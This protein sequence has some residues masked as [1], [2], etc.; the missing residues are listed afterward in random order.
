MIYIPEL[1][2]K[3]QWNIFKSFTTIISMM[4]ANTMYLP[5]QSLVLIFLLPLLFVI[6]GIQIIYGILHK[7]WVGGHL[8]ED[9]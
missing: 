8:Q 5:I 6:L 7:K 9:N 3:E 2:L 1:L 4:N